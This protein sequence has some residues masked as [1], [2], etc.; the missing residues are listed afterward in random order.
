MEFFSARDH[1]LVESDSL[2]PRGDPTLLFSGAGMN[3]FKDY[4]LGIR[5]D[6]KRAASCQKCLRTG[7]LDKVGRTPYHHSFFEML[8]NFSFGD[9]FKQEAI[10]WAWEFLTREIK[11]PREK[12]RVSVFKDDWDAFEIWRKDIGL[13]PGRIAQLGEDSNFWPAGVIQNGPNGPCGPCSEIFYDQG[14]ANGCGRAECSVTCDCGR[15]AEIWNLVFTQFDRQSDGT[16]KPLANQNIDTGMGLERLACVAQGKKYNYEIDLF[17]PLL[18]EIEKRIIKGDENNR[19]DRYALCDHIRAVTFAIGDGAYPSNEGRGYVIRKLI[20]RALWKAKR[21]GMMCPVLWELVPA[22]RK[23]MGSAYAQLA[24]EEH[25][26]QEVIKNEEERFMRTLD[27]GLKLIEHTKR[28][29]S[30]DVFLLYDTYGFPVE[31]TQSIAAERQNPFEMDRFEELMDEQRERAKQSSKISATVFSV[32]T[33]KETLARRSV[34]G[35]KFDGY[36][37]LDVKGARAKLL[38]NAEG[39]VC[40]ELGE[41][42]QGLL[43]TDRTPFYAESGG[44]V[45]DQ[46]EYAVINRR[47]FGD[48]LDTFKK[49]DI[50]FHR[51]WVAKGFVGIKDTL[52]FKVDSEKRRRTMYNHTATHLLH[53]GLR[54]ILG[55]HVR[56][57]GSVVEP[58]RLRFDFSHF[59]VLSTDEK[60]KVERLVTEQIQK[61]VAVNV[62]VK[63]LSMAKKDGAIAFFGEKYGK[64]VRVITVG[65]FSKELCGGT[66]V[67]NTQEIGAFKITSECSVGS[68]VRRIEAVTSLGVEEHAQAEARHRG[69]ERLRQTKRKEEEAKAERVADRQLATIDQGA[70]LEAA[71]PL[72]GLRVVIHYEKG[73]SK[74][75]L[76]ALADALK[77]RLKSGVVALFSETE[78]KLHVIVALSGNMESRAFDASQLTKEI[79]ALVGGHG[80]GRKDFAQGGGHVP[81]NQEDFCKRVFDIVKKSVS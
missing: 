68:G 47:A 64:Q 31:L 67:K 61:S 39:A 6:M 63:D 13:M 75:H 74:K 42:E 72:D 52:N 21:L 59:K 29:T 10:S 8:G 37:R 18:S 32:D 77:K 17:K 56:Q 62:S 43:V 40:E 79:S 22:V 33:L 44:Q 30:D 5:K 73:L 12:L 58:S 36:E 80:G 20:R 15:F 26:T 46:G 16:L 4:F 7:D 78:G 50:Y 23:A 49:D 11:I 57:L 53:A 69:E 19:T 70:L 38:V 71:K 24:E 81:E 51:I 55:E 35:T 25:Y 27:K 28:F 65:S 60:E 76:G 3:Q 48:V 14:E 66:H 34:G 9:Y 54:S 45:G 2:I 41:G 1:R